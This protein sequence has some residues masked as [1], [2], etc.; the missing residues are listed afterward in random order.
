MALW[1][2]TNPDADK[3]ERVL[4]SK[5]KTGYWQPRFSPN[6]RWLS[7]LVIGS[8]P[9]EI[10]V[11][12]ADG[13]RPERWIRIAAD[14][15]VPDKPR[16][17]PDGR[18]LYFI[19]RGPTSYF[20]LWAVRFDPERGTPV[21]EP[22]ALSKFDTPSLAISPDLA[23]SEMDVSA[24]HAVLT[25]KTVTGSIGCWTTWTGE[26]PSA[27]AAALLRRDSRRWACQP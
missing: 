12:P 6:G 14:H 23:A 27:F 11:A 13:S 26:G 3:P 4:I 21:G 15:I 19:A 16:W 17:A 24:R 9:N 25:M 18:T 1:P 5:P 7:F 8:G 20:N 10:V 2:T 22:F